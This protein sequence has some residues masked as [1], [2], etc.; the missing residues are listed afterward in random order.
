MEKKC[1]ICEKTKPLDE[2]HFHRRPEAKDGFRN[3]CREC[4]RKKQET[5]NRKPERKERRAEYDKHLR[6]TNPDWVAAQYAQQQDWH[7]RNP[8]WN[9]EYGERLE[10]KVRRKKENENWREKDGGAWARNRY[11]TN[12]EYRAQQLERARK[13]RAIKCQKISYLNALTWSGKIS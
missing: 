4:I 9:K 8:D 3:E 5:Y 12:A 7:Q 2:A 13:Q 1:R 6:A 11:A 10:V